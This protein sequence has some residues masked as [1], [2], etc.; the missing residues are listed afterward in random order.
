MKIIIPPCHVFDIK[1]T[2]IKLF[3]QWNT[4]INLVQ[5]KCKNKLFELYVTLISLNNQNYGGGDLVV[6]L[7]L[8]LATPWIV[9]C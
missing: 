1:S 3:R 6:K 5:V 9:T 4:I 7:C 8:T 2:K